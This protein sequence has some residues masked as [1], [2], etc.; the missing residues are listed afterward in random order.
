MRGLAQDRRV[1]RAGGGGGRRAR[2]ARGTRAL[3]A[4]GVARDRAEDVG[5]VGG[6]HR[7]ADLAGRP[8]ERG[9]AAGGQQQHL[10][11]DVEVGQR[12]GDHEHHAAGVGELAQ[13][14]HHLPVQRG[15]QAGG[16]LVEDQQRRPGQQ[17]QRHRRALA[18]TAG[19][20]V[21]AGVAGA[22]S[23]RVPR[24][25][26]CHDLVAV[27]LG[28]VRRQPQLGGVHQRLLARSADRAPRRP[29]APSRSWSA[30]RRTR[31]GCRGPRRTP[32]PWSGAC[33]RRPAGRTSTCRRPTARSP[34]SACR[35]ARTARC[36][37]AASCCPRSSR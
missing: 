20:L 2:C 8:A 11:A 15:V 35:A 31:R 6:A 3:A 12:V 14:R 17:F 19:Q 23:S 1:S 18:L 32:C 30:A 16:R 5:P 37:P 21:D 4:V 26:A 27:V 33:T 28:G 24:A 34:P 22:W 36:C 7:R 29:A 9:L 10:I 25:P 13:H